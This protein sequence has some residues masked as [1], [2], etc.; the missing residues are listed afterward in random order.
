M[1]PAVFI[2]Q[3]RRIPAVFRRTTLAGWGYF[4]MLMGGGN[5]YEARIYGEISVL[6]YVP[7]A[8]RTWECMSGKNVFEGLAVVGEKSWLAPKWLEWVA[9]IVPPLGVTALGWCLSHGFG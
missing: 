6:M 3:L 8:L 7:A 1:L 2:W 5:I 4:C 9:F